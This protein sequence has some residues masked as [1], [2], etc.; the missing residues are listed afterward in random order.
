MKNN[1]IAVAMSGGID[2]TFAAV[3]LQEMGYDVI[4]VTLKMFC[5]Q[6]PAHKKIQNQNFDDVKKICKQLSVPHYLIDVKEVFENVIINDFIQ[7]YIDGI[8]PNPCVICNK[9]IKWEFLL[10]KI[11]DFG[12]TKIATGHYAEV[13]FNKKFQR[14][15]IKRGEDTKKDQSYF[16]W[17]LNQNEL[18]KTVLPLGNYTKSEIVQKLNE[19]H[20]NIEQKEES[21]DICFI[22]DNDYN[23][24]LKERVPEAIHTGNIIDEDG[25]ILGEHKGIPFYTIGQRRGL[26]ISAPHPLYVNEI[27]KSSNEI[28]VGPES[29][30]YKKFLYAENCNWIKF[31]KLA[32]PIKAKVQIRYNSKACDCTVFPKAE[33][34]KVEFSQPQ[35]GIT[36]GQSAVFYDNDYV[37][38]GGIIQKSS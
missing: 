35:K 22:P 12:A 23:Y 11:M 5:H 38:G 20:L 21:Q 30:L 34:I 10:D 32:K 16:L 29:S 13:E 31:D 18:S 37:I 25:N 17:R 8:T 3:I 7:N 2:S 15:L 36:P 1:K 6:H 28:V 19:H 27:K 26:G 9:K 24:F 14:Y 33:G 4:G